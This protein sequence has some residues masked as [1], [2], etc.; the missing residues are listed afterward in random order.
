MESASKALKKLGD[1]LKELARKEQPGRLV[2]NRLGGLLML[3]SKI[4]KWIEENVIV[5]VIIVILILIICHKEFYKGERTRVKSK[6]KGR[7]NKKLLTKNDD[8]NDEC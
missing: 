7:K 6:I 8:D 2:L 5:F 4:F 3:G 1:K